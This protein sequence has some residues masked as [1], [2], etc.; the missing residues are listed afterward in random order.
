MENQISGD[1][2]ELRQFGINAIHGHLRWLKEI[3]SKLH[4]TNIYKSQ[5]DRDNL[6]Q[7]AEMAMDGIYPN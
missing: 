5:T 1:Y 2:S 6:L 7:P 3:Y 4:W